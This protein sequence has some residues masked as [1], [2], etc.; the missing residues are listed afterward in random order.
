VTQN[1]Q[2]LT[3]LESRNVRVLCGMVMWLQRIPTWQAFELEIGYT[4]YAQAC[5]YRY[6]GTSLPSSS[7]QKFQ[8]VYYSKKLAA[9]CHNTI[10][11][12]YQFERRYERNFNDEIYDRY[13]DMLDLARW[14][15]GDVCVE[16]TLRK[17]T[18]H[19]WLARL[20]FKILRK[21]YRNKPVRRYA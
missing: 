5:G 21:L 8:P 3:A 12:W 16:V 6:E 20:V 9:S 15:K 7:G 18:Q 2:M 13:R 17:S 10:H 11:T 1:K 4:S 19:T 14:Y